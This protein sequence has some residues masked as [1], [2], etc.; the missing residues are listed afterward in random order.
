M[1]SQ[2]RTVL[3]TGAT[4]GVGLALARRLHAMG[5]RLVLLARSSERLAQVR[6]SLPGSDSHAC[7]LADLRQLEATWARIAADHPELSVLVNNAAIQSTPRFVDPD[8]DPAEIEREAAVNFIAPARLSHLALGLFR[9]HGRASA[10]VNVSSGLAFHPK[11]NAAVY[12][13][14]KAA[15]H[16]LSRGLR[17]QLEG[18]PVAVVEAILPLVDTPMTAGRGSGKIT[19]DSA[20]AQIVD[21]IA[22]GRP[23]VYVGKARWLPV[24]SRISPAIPA[25]ILRRG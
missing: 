11:S 16:S 4:S 14:T 20:A 9:A 7:D 5:H 21:G 24:L 25:A 8:F 22:R 17:Y 2:P 18:T 10:I 13:A 19:A 6:Q 1:L 23:E 12:C 15:L 3:I